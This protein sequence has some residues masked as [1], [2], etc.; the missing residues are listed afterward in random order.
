MYMLTPSIRFLPP[1]LSLPPSQDRA[2]LFSSSDYTP[3]QPSH[4]LV[5]DSSYSFPRGPH[6]STMGYP[7]AGGGYPA[8]APARRTSQEQAAGAG[9]LV[10]EAMTGRYPPRNYP[11]PPPPEMHL[12]PAGRGG[13][14]VG[15]GDV[16][17]PAGYPHSHVAAHHTTSAQASVSVGSV[18]CRVYMYSCVGIHVHS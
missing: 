3:Q 7:Q 17:A 11:P 5:P 12:D 8:P 1:S 6:L 2:H 13:G 9:P 4:P 16:G 18:R 10:A 15:M 14:A